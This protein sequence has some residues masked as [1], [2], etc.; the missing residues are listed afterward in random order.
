MSLPRPTADGAAVIK[1]NPQALKDVTAE[2]EGEQLLR[3]ADQQARRDLLLDLGD[4][5][6]L[7]SMWLGKL[8]ALHKQ[9]QRRGGRLALV[10]VPAHV[11]E[12]FRLTSLDQFLDVRPKAAG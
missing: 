3:L 7:T 9:V 10:N 8:I 4:V 2:S 1:L 11:L 12:V 6:Y 5:P